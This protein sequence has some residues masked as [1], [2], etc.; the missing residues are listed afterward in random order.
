MA[1]LFFAG[2]A[3]SVAIVSMAAVLLRRS[4]EK[5]RGRIMGVRMLAI[6]SNMPGILAAGYL[7]PRYGFAAVAAAYACSACS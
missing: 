3:Q 1:V 4:D 5:F 2:L 7:L 6:Y